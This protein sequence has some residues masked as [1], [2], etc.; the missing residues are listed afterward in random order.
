MVV[1]RVNEDLV[2]DLAN[3]RSQEGK[4]A[5]WNSIGS[6]RRFLGLV[7]HKFDVALGD[8]PRIIV[9]DIRDVLQQVVDGE[10]EGLAF[11]EKM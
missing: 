8:L 7:E 10:L 4:R 6:R 5:I 2:D 9:L 3:S 1:R 11:S